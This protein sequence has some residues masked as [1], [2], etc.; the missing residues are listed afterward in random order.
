M[1]AIPTKLFE[2][3]EKI[4]IGKVDEGVR[5]FDRIDGFETYK[6]VPLAELC[7]FRHD[8]KHGMQFDKDFFDA[9]IV[10]DSLRYRPHYVSSLHMELMLVA[11]CQLGCWKESR[12]FFEELKTRN[13]SVSLERNDW[14]AF[15]SDLPKMISLVSDP[16]NTIRRL[17]ESMPKLKT[18][19]KIDLE[20]LERNIKRVLPEHRRRH[21]KQPMSYDGLAAHAFSKASTEDHAAFYEHYIDRLEDARSHFEAAKSYIALENI[22]EAKEAIRQYMRYWKFK[23]PFQVAPIILFT[24]YELWPIM[25]D[26]RFTESLLTIPHNRES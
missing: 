25:S 4:R 10:V 22:A 19:G 26:R 20:Y 24:D 11:T 15:R 7:Y 5:L 17:T 12:H 16:E 9:D 6:A 2:A 8:W 1:A 3:F 14:S 23:E 18:D 21:W 13:D